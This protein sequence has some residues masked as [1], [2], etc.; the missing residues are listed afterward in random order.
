MIAQLFFAVK[1]N[2]KKELTGLVL[3]PVLRLCIPALRMPVP[4]NRILRQSLL[5]KKKTHMF[6]RMMELSSP[7]HRRKP[8]RMTPAH[9]ETIVPIRTPRV[10]AFMPTDVRGEDL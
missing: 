9:G 4:A 3:P 8:Q 6:G 5:S 10:P 7:F 1:K 2:S